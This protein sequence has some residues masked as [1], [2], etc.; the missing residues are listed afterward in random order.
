MNTPMEL[1]KAV[2]AYAN[3]D[4]ES[5]NQVYELSYKYLHTCV[6]HVM[7]N[8]ETALDMLQETYLEISRNIT[9]LQSTDVFLNWAATIA[10]RKCFAYLKKQKEVLLNTGA[11]EE[12]TDI[13]ENIPDNE[14]LIPEEVLQSQEKQRLVKEIIDGLSDIQRLCVIGFYYNEQKQEEIAAELGIP[15]NTVKSHLN[16]AKAKIKNAVVDLDTKKGTRLYSFAPFMLLFFGMEAQ[17]SKAVPMPLAGNQAVVQAGTQTVTQASAQA[18]SQATVATVAVETAKATGMAFKTKV[19]IGAVIATLAVGGTAAGIAMNSDKGSKEDAFGIVYEKETSEAGGEV[20]ESEPIEEPVLPEETM[21]DTSEELAEEPG[22]SEYDGLAI[23]GLYDQYGLGNEGLIPVVKDGMYGLV[24]YDNEVVVPLQYTYGCME[25]NAE[26]Q[27][28]FGDGSMYYVF[29][30][31][32][33][34]IFSTTR[35]INA[36]SEGIVCTVDGRE[37]EAKIG[38]FRLSGGSALYVNDNEEGMDAN[39]VGFNEGYGIYSLSDPVRI[40]TAGNMLSYTQVIQEKEAAEREESNA[41]NVTVHSVGWSFVLDV[42]IGSVQEGYFAARGPWES[43]DSYGR[44]RVWNTEGT[45]NYTMD[46]GC[47]YDMLGENIW[48]SALSFNLIRYFEDGLFFY[49]YGTIMCAKVGE[50]YYLIDTAKVVEQDY[51][52]A[53][54]EITSGALLATGD[55][56]SMCDET[57]WLISQNGQ[58]GYMDHAGNVMAMYDDAAGFGDG[59]ALVIEDGIAYVINES[60][61]K[62]EEIGPADSVSNCGDI[63]RVVVGETDFFVAP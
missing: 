19:I 47:I 4:K 1:Q 18:G 20:V 13:F 6:M 53:K 12:V 16:R 61:E 55:Y 24:T 63:F 11:D 56:I 35:Q 60:F 3:G 41:G 49:N 2:I 43:E 17:A 62:V 33:N 42:P 21:E 50:S 59:K 57:Y 28:F 29:D 14:A 37:F 31:E 26:G 58:W 54:E 30:K 15:V 5:F 39:A 27:S 45:E 48:E 10:N 8:E 23:T 25:V 36:V 46:I 22:T 9:Q 38:Y 52:S 40:D 51:V 7:K 34:E 44:Y 32:G